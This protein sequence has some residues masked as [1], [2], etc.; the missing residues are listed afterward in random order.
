MKTVLLGGAKAAGRVA[1]V[2]D[3]DYDLVMAYRWHILEKVKML[4]ARGLDTVYARTHE[5]RNGKRTTLLMH[6][7]ITGWPQT[8]HADHNGLNNQR[9]NLREASRSQNRGNQRA[10]PGYHSQYKGVC[11]DLRYAN[12][13]RAYISGRSLGNF[14][15]E[16]EAARAYDAAAPEVFG[17]FAYLNFPPDAAA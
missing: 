17:E 9:Y 11:P 1:I 2:D 10:A 16:I 5:T 6:M 8:D 7:L 13:W 3:E 12:C 14:R 15:T 4:S